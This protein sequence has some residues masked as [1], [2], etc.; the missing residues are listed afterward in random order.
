MKPP[1][2]LSTLIGGMVL[3]GAHARRHSLFRPPP[4]PRPSD[5][6][7]GGAAARSTVPCCAACR[8]CARRVLPIAGPVDAPA[9][10]GAV[11]PSRLPC[12]RRLPRPPPAQGRAS[13]PARGADG[14]RTCAGLRPPAA[15]PRVVRTTP[16]GGWAGRDPA[17]AGPAGMDPAGDIRLG[18]PMPRVRSTAPAGGTGSRRGRRAHS[19]RVHGPLTMMSR[20]GLE[21]LAH[22]TPGGEVR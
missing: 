4:W 8:S 7:P 16:I 3:I 18:G 15:A 12:A 11:Q 17:G 1:L 9:S 14:L 22:R 21:A 5:R 13:A 19:A 20:R 6:R 10:A 2:V